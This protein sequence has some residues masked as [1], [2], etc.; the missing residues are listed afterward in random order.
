MSFC[1]SLHRLKDLVG[2]SSNFRNLVSWKDLKHVGFESHDCHILMQYLL[3]VITRGIL[4]SQVRYKITNL[5][6]FFR[7]ISSKVIDPITLDNLQADVI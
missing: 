3:P 5:C 2:Y 6:F 4:P 1:E 7:T